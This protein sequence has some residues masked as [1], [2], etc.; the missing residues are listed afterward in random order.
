MRGGTD[1]KVS[2]NKRWHSEKYNIKLWEFWKIELCFLG[3]VSAEETNTTRNLF[4]KYKS[5]VAELLD[6]YYRLQSSRPHSDKVLL[7]IAVENSMP[8]MILCRLLLQEK[9]KHKNLL[10]SDISEM[11]KLHYLIEDPDFAGNVRICSMNDNQDG[12]IV[13]M[14]RR[15][16]GEEYEMKLKKCARD[17][18]IAY[19]DENDLR[20]TGFDKTPDLKLV[21]PFFYSGTVVNWIESK[22]LFGDVKT[23]RKYLTQQLQSY[24]NRFGPGIVIYW[25]GFH[26]SL[27]T[28]ED[29]P[30][31]LIVLNRFPEKEN[32]VFLTEI[33]ETTS[34]SP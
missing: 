14:R 25:F 33:S 23:H 11:M 19:F 2:R 28:F 18:G 9:Y 10:K 24:H 1:K 3:I 8:P 6:R 34:S 13:D 32:I 7:Q 20:R 5:R 16:L 22:A 31:G 17:C 29:N 27:T 15:C 30:N 4:H 26:E 12:I 21:L